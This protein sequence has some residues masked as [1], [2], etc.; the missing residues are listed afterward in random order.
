[1][2]LNI[3]HRWEIPETLVTWSELQTMSNNRIIATRGYR[4]VTPVVY[5]VITSD[6]IT[7]TMFRLKFLGNDNVIV[8]KII[9]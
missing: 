4:D 7:E 5:V 3:R 8:T 2:T 1:M 9:D 6:E